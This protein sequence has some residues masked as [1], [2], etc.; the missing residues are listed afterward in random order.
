MRVSQLSVIVPAFNAS[1]TIE[2]CVSSALE[3]G[4]T[5]VIVVDDGS[6]DNTAAT[7]RQAGAIVV[8]QSNSGA[9]VARRNGLRRSAKTATAVVFLDSDDA[10]IA[11]GVRAAVRQIETEGVV[12]VCG[13]TVGIHA[14]GSET[15]LKAWS[16]EIST[17][18]L[19]ERGYGPCPPASVVWSAPQLRRAMSDEIAAIWPRYAE[20]YELLIRGS[21]LGQ[22]TAISEPTSRYR[23]T[24]GKSAQSAISSVRDAETIRAHYAGIANVH[25]VPRSKRSQE[26]LALIRNA[27]GERRGGVRRYAL[28]L[29]A[30]AKDPATLVSFAV[31]SLGQRR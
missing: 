23:M 21:L 4:A 2:E 22:I 19:L 8:T 25:V 1:A 6:T 31:Q 18:S 20:D 5:E 7:A 26:S 9:A 16:T 12:A 30:A 15:L 24:G 3:A 29:R 28:L 17:T 27:S 13:R 10:L 14:D 11:S